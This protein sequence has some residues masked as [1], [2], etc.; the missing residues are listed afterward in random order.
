VGLPADQ[1]KANELYQ[2]AADKGNTQA[3]LI[4]ADH[5]EHGTGGLRKAQAKAKELR[6]KAGRR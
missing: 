1:G 3:L 6:Q 2:K 5:Y 4:L